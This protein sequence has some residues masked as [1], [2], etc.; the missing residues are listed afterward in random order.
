M[1]K[2]NNLNSVLIDK[3][4][5]WGKKNPIAD[6]YGWQEAGLHMKELSKQYETPHLAVQNWTLAS[7]LAWYAK[8]LEVFVLDERVDQFDIWSGTLPIGSDALVLDWSQMA[9]L[10]PVSNTGFESCETLSTQTVHRLGRNIAQFDF[11]LCKNWHG[12]FS[13]QRVP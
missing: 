10:V 4:H 7:R 12:H 3:N 13:P 6:L 1:F 5:A 9:F 11:L 2:T 8:P